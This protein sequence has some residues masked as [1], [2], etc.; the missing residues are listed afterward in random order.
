MHNYVKFSN[1]NQLSVKT[2]TVDFFV[3]IVRMLYLV[4]DK[5]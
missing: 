2:Q 4:K 5:L 1:L 3:F